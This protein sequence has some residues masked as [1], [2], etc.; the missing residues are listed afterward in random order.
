MIEILA[1]LLIFAGAALMAVAAVGLLRL[2][3]FY[4]RM[5]ATT[6]ATTLGVTLMTLGAA[7][8]FNDVS[9]TARVLAIVLFLF[10]T[11]PIG[12]HVIGRAAYLNGVRLWEKTVVDQ[13][14]RQPKPAEA[15]TTAMTTV[16]P[17]QR[18]TGRRRPSTTKKPRRRR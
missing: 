5:A 12:A 6:K 17:R 18:S 10:L 14:A 1:G 3:D 8:V 15:S 16:K 9:V 11:A 2:P 4:L 13:W 7:L